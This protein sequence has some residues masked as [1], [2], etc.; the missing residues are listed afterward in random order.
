MR[1]HKQKYLLLLLCCAL[2]L[3]PVAGSQQRGSEQNALVNVP[4]QLRPRLIERLNLLVEYERTQQWDRM[5]DLLGE[6]FKISV[7][8]GMSRERWLRDRSR[9]RLSRFTPKSAI[10]LFG[11]EE[12]GY[13]IIL[14]CGEYSRRGPNERLESSVEA[15]REN[16]DW[17]F[18]PIG[19]QF[20][21]IHCQARGCRH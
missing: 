9:S 16:G 3:T 18:S 12:T 6:Q 19:V 1:N 14:G 13:W 20:P 17:Y 8:G 21:C 2:F 7:E 4:E 5:Y 11:T 10:L 15:Y